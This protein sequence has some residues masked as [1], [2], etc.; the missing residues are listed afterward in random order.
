VQLTNGKVF[1]CD[2]VVSATGVIPSVPRFLN[3]QVS[4]LETLLEN[5]F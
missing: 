5:G 2:Y 4:K 1:G 3:I